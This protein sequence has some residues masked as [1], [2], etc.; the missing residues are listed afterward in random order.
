MANPGV[1]TD[2]CDPYTSATGV[3]P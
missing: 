2:T 3:S 1:V